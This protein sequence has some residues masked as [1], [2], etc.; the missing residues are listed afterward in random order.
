MRP[1]AESARSRE[2]VRGVHITSEGLQDNTLEGR[3][4]AWIK[5]VRR[6]HGRNGQ[7]PQRK[8]TR[9]PTQA[10]C[11]LQAEYSWD[12]RFA[13]NGAF[14]GGH[15]GITRSG[16]PSPK[17]MKKLRE[18][19]REL[20]RR[21]HSGKDVKPII[22]ELTPV[23]RG[24]GNYFRDGWKRWSRDWPYPV[25]GQFNDYRVRHYGSIPTVAPVR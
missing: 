16:W 2:R 19:V 8:S 13:R 5:L 20:S 11:V 7:H 14:R 21:R 23:L 10:I 12:A 4:P 18:R 17:A 25:L 24:W 1:E 22:V 6:G 3:G 9:T 15:T